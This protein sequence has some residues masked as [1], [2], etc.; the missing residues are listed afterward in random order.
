VTTLP[1]SARPLAWRDLFAWR[2]VR[3]ALL[4]ALPFG[5]LMSLASETP[6]RIW[7][8]RVATVALSAML[9]Y[10]VLERWPAVPPRRLARWVMQLLGIVGVIPLA[11]YVAYWA[12]TGRFDFLRIEPEVVVGYAQ[13]TFVGVLVAPWLALGAMV[14]QREAF[15]REQ[16]LAFQLERSELERQAS[17]ARLHLLQAQVAPHFLFNTLANVRALVKTGSPRAPELLDSLIDYLRAAVPRLDDSASTVAQE[18]ELVRAY[19]ALMQM[20]MPDRLHYT[21][22]ADDAAL[23]LRCPP[24]SVLTLV[25]NAVRHGIDP[26][27]DGGAIAVTVQHLGTR[28][29]LRVVDGGIGLQ[30]AAP[31]AGLGTGLATLRERLRLAFGDG[32]RL[33]IT[34]QVPRGTCAEI[35]W[36]LDPQAA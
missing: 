12:T 14:R 17:D 32:A 3:F 23:A 26:S 15:A 33:R 20:R 21:L 8:V 29:L 1:S 31:E 24:L 6:L 18:L 11:A 34:A 13:L 36:P 22:H 2:R 5:L 7:L 4:A 16:A 30:A 19:L 28:C 27:E 25:E 9:V 35:E 10:G